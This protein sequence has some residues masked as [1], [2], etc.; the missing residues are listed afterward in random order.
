M[1]EQMKKEI[2]LAT[3]SGDTIKKNILKL[4]V[5]EVQLEESRRN[6]PLK[7]QE[8]ENIIKKFIKN[9]EE[10]MSYMK[11]KDPYK[12][13]PPMELV[14]EITQL[15]LWLPIKASKKEIEEALTEHC[16]SVIIGKNKGQAMGIAMKTLKAIGLSVDGKDVEEVVNEIINE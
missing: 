3:K 13:N 16:S 6:K 2:I 10:T 4:V 8:I 12:E 14:E 5:S 11:N 7:D 1:I 9:I 15:M